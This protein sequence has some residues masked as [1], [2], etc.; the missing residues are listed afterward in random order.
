MYFCHV[1]MQ[2]SR[3]TPH[4]FP[5]Q[6]VQHKPNEAEP[7]EHWVVY[8]YYID[9][10]N[11]QCNT[12]IFDLYPL[13]S[14]LTGCSVIEFFGHWLSKWEAERQSITVQVTWPSLGDVLYQVAF[15]YR[16][17][18]GYSLFYT[19]S[20]THMHTHCPKSTVC[21]VLSDNSSLH[22]GGTV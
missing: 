21:S 7:K 19:H 16:K 14:R 9:R 17:L 5:C 22:W 20:H 12:S 15:A 4:P 1:C 11:D 2:A 3:E 6:I 8:M 18:T 13:V 10:L